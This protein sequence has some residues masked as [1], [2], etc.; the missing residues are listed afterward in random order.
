M[1]AAD[2]G[3]SQ[4]QLRTQLANY[5][6][7]RYGNSQIELLVNADELDKD[8]RLSLSMETNDFVIKTMKWLLDG[9]VS[10][11]RNLN[12]MY[13]KGFGCIPGGGTQFC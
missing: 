12:N 5:K 2:L 11:G 8:L 4:D 10:G 6:K 13:G 3:L 1:L 9:D 7:S